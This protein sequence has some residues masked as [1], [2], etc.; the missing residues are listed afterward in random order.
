MSRIISV[1]GRNFPAIKTTEGS[2]GEKKGVSANCSLSDNLAPTKKTLPPVV[3][4]SN[5]ESFNQ[6]V[7]YE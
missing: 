5:P 4:F 7:R 2:F 6:G 3:V 1:I